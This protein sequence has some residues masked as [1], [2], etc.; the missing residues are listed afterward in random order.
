M[1]HSIEEVLEDLRQGK[2][3]IVMDDE[4]R[5]NEGDL[6]CAAEKITPDTVN[7]MARHARGLICVPMESDRLDELDLH[8][9]RIEI[10]HKHLKDDTAWT[11]SVDASKG[12][13]TGIS[14]ADRAQTVKTLINMSSTPKD[15]ITPGHIFPLRAKK[16]GVLVRAGHTEASVDLTRLAGLYPAGV[17][18]EIMNE[19]GTMARNPDLKKFSKE[20]DIKMCTID[21]LIE[22]RR[23]SEQLVEK[24]QKS[25]IT[26]EYGN[27]KL[28]IYKSQ[29]DGSEH[30][31][32]IKGD[33]SGAKPTL[34]RVHAQNAIGDTFRAVG[35]GT[36]RLQA[37]LKAIE[38]NG[39]GILIYMMQDR[40]GVSL[41]D[42]VAALN[43]KKQASEDDNRE[44]NITFSSE[45]R[46]YGVGAQ[47]LVELG[48]RQLRLL[49]NNPRKIVGL[50][51]YGLSIS[52]RVPLNVETNV[53]G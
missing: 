48:V 42:Q 47:I 26:T 25:E 2:I 21:S 3:V 4:G 34:V 53:V 44:V 36:G 20:H 32:L 43:S 5:E 13:T 45:L 1:F 33:I 27:F 23:Q 11:I 19:D 18:C 9:M 22:Y 30:I 31:A 17:I 10:G 41:S 46:H 39:S 14:A 16:G 51:G 6:L 50:E 7:F 49:T 38:D 52:E 24:I 12:V 29:V 15:F 35:G 28:N 37:A 40:E 8:P